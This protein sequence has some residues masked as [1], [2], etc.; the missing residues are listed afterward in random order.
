MFDAA[1][2]TPGWVALDPVHA[3]SVPNGC[4]HLFADLT[5]SWAGRAPPAH[6]APSRSSA[7]SKAARRR[8]FSC[9]GVGVCGSRRFDPDRP[10][11]CSKRV[12]HP[13]Y[14]PAK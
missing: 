14:C 13:R 12:Y 3:E 4:C 1:I 7:L 11:K 6:A 2:R 5:G 9:I 8:D 10:K